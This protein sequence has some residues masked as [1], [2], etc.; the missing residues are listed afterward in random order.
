MNTNSAVSPLDHELEQALARSERRL[1]ALLDHCADIVALVD[2]HG[3]I[4]YISPAVQRILGYEPETLIGHTTCA[5]I[6][7]EEW[8]LIANLLSALLSGPESQF[9]TEVRAQHQDGSWRWFET[10]AVNSLNDPAVAGIVVNLHD[11]TARKQAET[12]LRERE[13][14]LSQAQKLEVIGRLAGGIA[15]DFN[16]LLTVILGNVDLVL[17]AAAHIPSIHN[18]AEGIRQAA[19]RATALIRQLLAFSRQQ[20]LEPRLLDLNAVIADM[21]QLLRRL[22]GT[23]ITLVTQLAT[24]LGHVRAD[25]G[26]IEQVLMNLVVN[27]RD[28]MPAGGRLVIETAHASI[29]QPNTDHEQKSYVT[30]TVRD[31]GSGMDDTTRARIFEPFFTTKPLGKGTGLGLPI[32]YG[33][34][35]QSGGQIEV[36]SEVG[37]G[38]TFRIFLPRVIGSNIKHDTIR[39]TAT[40][41]DGNATILLVEDEAA[42]RALFVRILNRHG[43]QVLEAENGPAAL[44]IAASYHGTIALLLTDVMMP[45]GLS[46]RQLVEQLSAERPNLKALYMSGYAESMLTAAQIGPGETFLQKPFTPAALVN[47]IA[48]LIQ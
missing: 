4:Q 21:S 23:D 16:N 22:I 36:S 32:V 35:T 10:T 9:T 47:K 37:Q 25:P 6:H 20:M 11:V 26:Q 7:A 43:Y 24:D 17:A 14:Q 33:I 34:V 41:S 5:L 27:A 44:Q 13:Q 12:A 15:H 31:T 29:V 45:G 8:E 3:V 40:T 28:A 18:D 38:T 46:A 2:Q 39:N 42:L 30:L 48:E 1:R 19:E